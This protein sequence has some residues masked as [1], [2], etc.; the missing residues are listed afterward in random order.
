MKGWLERTC[1]VALTE[2]E[3]TLKPQ[4][5][6]FNPRRDLPDQVAHTKFYGLAR[7]YMRPLFQRLDKPGLYIDLRMTPRILP[8]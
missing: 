1:E 5:V 2:V 7:C 4:A 3:M 8:P 6:A